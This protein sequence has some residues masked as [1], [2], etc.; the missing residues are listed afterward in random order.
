MNMVIICY[1]LTADR[2]PSL[3]FHGYKNSPFHRYWLAIFDS[4][5]VQMPGLEP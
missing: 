5:Y 3:Q 2:C 1:K 4:G